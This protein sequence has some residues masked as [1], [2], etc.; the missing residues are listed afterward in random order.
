[1][2][3][4]IYGA[5]AIG[6]HLGGMLTRSGVDVSLIARGPHLEAMQQNGL[7]CK[8]QDGE[9]FRVH[10]NATDDPASLGPQ[11]YVIV[12]LKAHQSPGVV[13]LMQPLMGPDT[14]DAALDRIIKDAD[15]HE[16]GYID[17]EEFKK[18]MTQGE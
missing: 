13:G 16:N 11:N 9:E 12:T 2:K 1:M 18:M 4:A 7:L 8:F 17:L 5:G 3:I 15:Y 10:P 6:A 14:A